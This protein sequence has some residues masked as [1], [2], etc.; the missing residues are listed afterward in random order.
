MAEARSRGSAQ[1]PE[2]ED[3]GIDVRVYY[4]DTDAAG[5]VYHANYLRFFE[6]A[7]TDWLRHCGFDHARLRSEHDLLL[8]VAR[9]GTRYIKPAFLDDL[10][11]VTVTLDA[12]RPAS[13]RM[14]QRLFR[15]N[16][17]HAV[18]CTAQVRI[19]CVNAGSLEPILLPSAVTTEIE[20]VH[21]PLTH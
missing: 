3:F 5:I 16:E 11:R 6:R 10:L 1:G 2:T 20:R 18:L 9:L 15:V 14:S 19:A 4:E 7:R 12:A 21:G 8:T 17:P 13:L